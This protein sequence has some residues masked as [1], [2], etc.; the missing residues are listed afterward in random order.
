[1]AYKIS[2]GLRDSIM[3]SQDTTG[4][5]ATLAFTETTNIV[6]TSA[7]NF[8]T[9][10]FRP[11]DT[12]TISGSGLN[13]MVTT[14]VEIASNGLTMEVAGALANEAEGATVTITA[15]AK[16]FKDTFRNS[17]IRV[18]AG[19]VPADAD[20]DE[21]AGALLLKIT[22]TSG[23]MVPGGMKQIIIDMFLVS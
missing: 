17:I 2:T 6:T 20:A 5:V 9:L 11:E 15:V 13:D 21:G 10:G 1:M 14:I 12:I 18:Y 19:T 4:A 3:G 7:Q 16:T 22:V 8:L 23:A